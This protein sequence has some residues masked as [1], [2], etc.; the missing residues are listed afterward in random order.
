[1]K[2][3]LLLKQLHK[4]QQKPIKIS[5]THHKQH[6]NSYAIDVLASTAAV[7]E[8]EICNTKDQKNGDDPIEQQLKQKHKEMLERNRY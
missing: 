6:Q 4:D 8:Y 5:K 7:Q 1:M 2:Q 3:N